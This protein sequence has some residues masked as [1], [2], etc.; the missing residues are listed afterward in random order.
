MARYAVSLKLKDSA[1]PKE[2][3]TYPLTLIPAQ[4]NNPEQIFTYEIREGLRKN[5]QQQSGCKINDNHLQ[6]IINTWIEDIQEGYRDTLITLDLPP[7]I[8]ANIEQ[9][10]ETGN[11]ELPQL[12]DP[13]LS[14]IEPILGMLPPLNF[15]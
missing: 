5:L 11:Q 3:Y 12:I 10:Q 6:Q 1:D 9:I 13:D 2:V 14:E 15:C 8:A 4:E 7:L